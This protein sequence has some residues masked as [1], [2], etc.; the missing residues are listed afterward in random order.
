[1]A[2]LCI[3]ELHLAFTLSY[4]YIRTKYGTRRDFCTYIYV[5]VICAWIVRQLWVFGEFQLH[6]GMDSD[7]LCSLVA[8]IV[9][10]FEVYLINNCFS[11]V[12]RE[13]CVV[14]WCNGGGKWQR[15]R[16]IPARMIVTR[17]LMASMTA[18]LRKLGTRFVGLNLIVTA[19]MKRI[20][21][22]SSEFERVRG[23]V[24]QWFGWCQWRRWRLSGWSTDPTRA[25][26]STSSWPGGYP[27]SGN[28]SWTRNFFCTSI[29]DI[30]INRVTSLR[31]LCRMCSWQ[32]DNSSTL[33]K[34]LMA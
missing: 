26:P 16:F 6:Y 22:S 5:R 19:T 33:C 8:S 10:A 24:Q 32:V 4:V 18:I 27:G 20:R 30:S 17:V 12:I 28:W 34:I 9:W 3:S 29:V 2:A 23:R 31:P 15:R 11:P 25:R 14:F 1:M 13:F 21:A 7:F